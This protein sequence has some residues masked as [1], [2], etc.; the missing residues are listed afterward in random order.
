M[1]RAARAAAF[2]QLLRRAEMFEHHRIEFE[3][4]STRERM[5]DILKR[6]KNQSFATF[7]SL[8]T[9]HEGRLG[10]IVTFLAVMELVKESLIDV[11]QTE[12][13]GPLHVKAKLI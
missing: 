1:S 5:S 2:G 6:L 9:E 12:A 11:V 3:N 8:L 10:V 4:L 7:E 13:F